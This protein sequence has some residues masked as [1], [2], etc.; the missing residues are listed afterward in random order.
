MKYRTCPSCS[1]KSISLAKLALFG[2]PKCTACSKSVGFHWLF[3]AVY[4]C[5]LAVLSSFFGVYLVVSNINVIFSF[6]IICAVV[7][8]VSALASFIAPLETKS[9]WWAP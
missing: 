1:E 5:L 2:R 9:K 8:L 3:A 6:T 7:F 4:A